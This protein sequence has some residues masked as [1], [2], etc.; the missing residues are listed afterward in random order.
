MLEGK[1]I[2]AHERRTQAE[3]SKRRP[4]MGAAAWRAPRWAPR[5]EGPDPSLRGLGAPGDGHGPHPGAAHPP[6]ELFEAPSAEELVR[7]LSMAERY[8]EDAFLAGVWHTGM[9]EVVLDGVVVS[10]HHDFGFVLTLGVK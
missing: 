6:K 9:D 2:P 1:L 4:G 10:A 5:R 7:V 8:R 3:A